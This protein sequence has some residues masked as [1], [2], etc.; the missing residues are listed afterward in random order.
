[1][2]DRNLDFDPTV[3]N[4][5]PKMPDQGA[6]LGVADFA[7][8]VAEVSA[9]SKALN[10]TA[11]TAL[12][13]RQL[14]AG[15][16]EATAG[17]PNDPT[18]LANLQSARATV[19]Q[20]IGSQ[21]PAIASQQYMSKVI[22]LGESSDKL[23]EFWGM[24]Q[25]IRNA[26]SNMEV[27]RDTHLQMANQAGMQF[28]KD[29]ADF[30]NLN[31]VLNYEQAQQDIKDFVTPVVGEPKANAYLKDFSGDWVKSFT[32]GLAESNPTAA[33]AMLQ[34]PEIAEHFTSEQIGDMG[35][36]I[37]KTTRQQ[38]LIQNLQ[39]TKADGSLAGII[40]DPNTTYFEKRATIDKL[41]ASGDVTPKSAAAARRVIKST[42][43]LESQTDTPAM[44]GIINKVYDLNSNASASADDYLNGVQNL[45]SQ[46]LQAQAAGQLTG[47][48]ASKVTNQIN[49]LTS[50][51]LADAT[52]TAGMEFYDANQKFNALPPEY[53]GQA[54]RA[55]FYA[56]QNQNWTPAQYTNNA[57]QI[58]DQINQQ[59]RGAAQKT[60]SSVSQDDA[61][62]LKTIPNTS[63]E[64][65]QLTAKQYGISTQQVVL[66]LRAK[67][68][69]AARA[70]QN[71]ITRIAPGD[72]GK[73]SDDEELKSGQLKMPLKPT[74][75][76][77]Q[78]EEDQKAME[79]TR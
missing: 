18:A 51:K 24:H 66:Q 15:Y 70:K 44:A 42:E 46:V 45:H 10:A 65:I 20:K 69:D 74:D 55:L 7:D 35:D 78:M 25:Q 21:V 33:A 23:N 13:F 67:A 62:F 60:L 30:G 12:A 27:A 41:D 79:L 4:V 6:M 76:I 14:D 48:D 34:R 52:N 72:D 68:A 59:R 64:N 38:Q 9:N 16:R 5:T 1:M 22:E 56:G 31:S 54:T 73:D 3:T 29:G 71:G 57:G 8:K 40:N 17:N 28:G 43:D 47:R 36:L 77:D 26:D 61:S 37:K 49:D 63:P 75:N 50:K 53:R 39:T 32:S 19:A 11:Q 2:A 58:I